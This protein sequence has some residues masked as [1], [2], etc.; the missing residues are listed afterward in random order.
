MYWATFWAIFKQTHL[1]TLHEIQVK[2]VLTAT[3][4]SNLKKCKVTVNS[5]IISRDLHLTVFDN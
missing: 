5:R 1:V 4:H 2:T 3:Q